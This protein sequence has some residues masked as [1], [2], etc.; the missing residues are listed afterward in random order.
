MQSIK[1]SSAHPRVW[2]LGRSFAFLLVF[3]LSIQAFAQVELPPVSPEQLE[4]AMNSPQPEHEVVLESIEGS[5]NFILRAAGR[6]EMVEGQLL[7]F[8]LTQPEELSAEGDTVSG[9]LAAGAT[10]FRVFG[11]IRELMLGQPNRVRVHVDLPRTISP[12][13]AGRGEAD[14]VRT[15]PEID[16]KPR[17]PVGVVAPTTDSPADQ[18]GEEQGSEGGVAVEAADDG[19][20]DDEENEAW[21]FVLDGRAE[22]TRRVG[23]GE[24]QS[25]QRLEY[26]ERALNGISMAEAGD[27][28]C[29]LRLYAESGNE[30]IEHPYIGC[31]YSDLSSTKIVRYAKSFGRALAGL[32]PGVSA[33][34][35]RH[36]Q[37]PPGYAV[38]AM[39]VCLNNTGRNARIKGI[40]VRGWRPL[41]Y[42]DPGRDPAGLMAVD[43]FER[44]NCRHRRFV[45]CPRRSI[46]TG[47]VA[48]LRIKGEK[49]GWINQLGLI[50]RPIERS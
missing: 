14:V 26:A 20:R 50:C 36:A 46:A 28:P 45:S 23:A 13:P 3:G 32:V 4:R 31:D 6:I 12:R 5:S 15:I 10:G 16:V 43:S 25:T 21:R 39:Q 19:L 1:I 9:R 17:P 34:S 49:R 48:S 11:P 44:N 47:V 37:L 42:L 38:V 29:F 35:H 2:A 22:G 18:G 41:E 30:D 24:T 7:G 8:D 40:E 27:R 33:N